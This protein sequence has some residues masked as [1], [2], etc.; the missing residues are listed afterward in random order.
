M[1]ETVVKGLKKVFIVS[2]YGTEY[3][4]MFLA[5]GWEVVDTMSSA[6]LVQFTG[7]SDVT[8]S[9]YGQHAHFKTYNQP[10]RDAFEVLQFKAAQKAGLP[11]A[12][13]CRGGQFLNVM[14]GGSLWQHVEGHCGPHLAQ[15]TTGSEI[16]D[17]MVSSTHHQM[18]IPIN[19]P[20]KYELLMSARQEGIKE[21]CGGTHQSSKQVIKMAKDK[22]DVE[23]LFY[24]EKKCLCFQPHPEFAGLKRLAALYFEYLNSCFSL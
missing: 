11:M 7:G 16:R 19:N 4:D 6:D 2:N 21:K 22:K 12:G 3:T 8:P 23:A 15:Y 13:I 5:A 24:H 10:A 17:I 9:L 18:I 20:K 1:E 14:C